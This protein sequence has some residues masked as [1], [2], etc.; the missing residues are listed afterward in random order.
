MAAGTKSIKPTHLPP[1]PPPRP[2]APAHPPSPPPP[3]PLPRPAPVDS[4]RRKEVTST[5]TATDQQEH[6]PVVGANGTCDRVPT[7]KDPASTGPAR[8]S[9]TP[10][11]WFGGVVRN[12]TERYYVGQID[13]DSNETGLSAYIQDRGPHVTYVRL[14]RNQRDK[15]LSAQVNVTASD[16]SR[17]LLE[18]GF[19]PRGIRCREWKPRSQWNNQEH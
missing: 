2:Y 19:W 13:P 17:S 9:D 1:L 8:R 16:I 11:G 12:R 7:F 4:D 6:I 14:M 10:I 5:T 18:R 15:T 3:P